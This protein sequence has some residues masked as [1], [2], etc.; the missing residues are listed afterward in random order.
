[1]AADPLPQIPVS[2]EPA[3][4]PLS[5][6]ARILN[7]YIAP[8]KTFTD[9]RRS[10]SWWGPWILVSIFSLAVMFTMGKKI[11]FEQVSRNQISQS[12][13]AA[14]RFDK[15]SPDQ[16]TQQ[17][18]VSAKIISYIGYA[19]PLVILLIFLIEATVLW[20]TFNVGA[21]GETSFTQAYAI[22]MY[23]GL[24][25]VIHAILSIVSMFAGANPE[26]FDINNPVG[27]NL[28][29]Y[30]DPETTSKAIRVLASSLDVINIWTIIL[31]GIGFACT[32]K[33]K[34]STAIMIV[35]GWYVVVKLIA[36]GFA[37]MG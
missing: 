6:G 9:L 30:L 22:V 34:R 28:G 19:T 35:A 36:T 29:Y 5:E 4:A 15:L 32:S 13:K 8:S 21:G 10:A 24:P 18:Q 14:D 11:G 17:I 20:V 7:T 12:P 31:I 26:S 33:V 25:G 3:A 2:T 16:Q 27:T 1:M 37:A 23:A